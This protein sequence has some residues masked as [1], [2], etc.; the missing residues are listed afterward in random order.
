MI[1]MDFFYYI[2]FKYLERYVKSWVT[3][4]NLSEQVNKF[5]SRYLIFLKLW[6]L[7]DSVA[8][9]ERN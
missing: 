6:K 4:L 5:A 2:K 7:V 3:V 8:A 1:L 9:F